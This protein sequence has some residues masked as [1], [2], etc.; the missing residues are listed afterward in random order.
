MKNK[1]YLLL[2]SCLFASCSKE[3]VNNYHIVPYPNHLTTQQGEFV[4]NNSTKL[5]LSS[6]LDAASKKVAQQ[7]AND[8]RVASSISFPIIEVG[9]EKLSHS[10]VAFMY[11]S[12]LGTKPIN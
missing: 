3:L 11:Q 7:F 2:V 12:E 4:F 5:L 8:L 9:E 1:I 6:N 10:S